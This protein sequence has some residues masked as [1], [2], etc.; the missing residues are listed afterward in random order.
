MSLPS[1]KFVCWPVLHTQWSR[2]RLKV[3]VV[4]AVHRQQDSWQVVSYKKPV[5]Q[6]RLTADEQVEQ[7]AKETTHDDVPASS[8]AL[9]V[10]KQDELH[11]REK[12]QAEENLEE[13]KEE[14][15]GV[16]VYAGEPMEEMEA[17]PDVTSYHRSVFFFVPTWA[18]CACATQLVVQQG[19]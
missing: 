4:Q 19:K 9:E 16:A 11:A 8:N 15:S 13:A 7:Q 18:Y 3:F 2:S 17:E 10:L 12:Q 1:T 14:V 5:T 6:R